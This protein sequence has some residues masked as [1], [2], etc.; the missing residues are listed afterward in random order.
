MFTYLTGTPYDLRSE[1]AS[2]SHSWQIPISVQQRFISEG[3]EIFYNAFGYYPHTAI[4][5]HYL[6][7]ENTEIALYNEGIRYVQGLPYHQARFP[8]N[9]H[10]HFLGEKNRN[11]VYLI[12]L[13]NLEFQG[14]RNPQWDYIHAFEEI[15]TAWKYG[16]PAIVSTHRLN[17]VGSIDPN[18]HS[19]GIRQLD[20]LLKNLENDFGDEVVYLSDF[21]LAQLLDVGYSIQRYGNDEY[22]CRNYVRNH[23]QKFSISIPQNWKDYEIINLN[24]GA[25]IKSEKYTRKS[26]TVIRFLAHEGDY[27]IHRIE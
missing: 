24:S 7:D 8:H 27:I 6:W 3:K 20:C 16:L 23:T 26:S 21:E 5:P 13:I 25:A 9:M 18:M 2:A 19:S 14:G 17:Y 15:A 4:A 11:V 22:I 12:R 10:Y 1:F